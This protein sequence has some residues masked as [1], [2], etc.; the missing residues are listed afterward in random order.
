MRHGERAQ[1]KRGRADNNRFPC[2][3]PDPIAAPA[4]L[5]A[6][7]IASARALAARDGQPVLG[8][9]ERETGLT[10]DDLVQALGRTLAMGTVGSDELRPEDA[11]FDALPFAEAAER[12][13]VPIR[14]GGALSVVYADPFRSEV[15][16]WAQSR[17][18]EP[19]AWRLA[20]PDTIERFFRLLEES[21]RELDEVVRQAKDGTADRGPAACLVSLQPAD[22]R[23]GERAAMRLLASTLD[24]ALASG[25]SD[26][27]LETDPAGLVVKHRVDGVLATVARPRDAQLAGQV[28]AQLKANAGLDVA[29]RG[30][31]QAGR[32]RIQASRGVDLRLSILPGLHG[33]DAVLRILDKQSAA[34]E[35]RAPRLDRLGLQPH[36][37]AALHSLVAAPHGLVLL[38]GPA[39]C[40][41][42]TTAY[43]AIAQIR[44]GEHRIATLEDP[45]EQA[46]PGILQVAVDEAR[47]ITS[48]QGLRAILGHDPD[49]I[50]VGELRD[51]ETARIAVQAALGGRLVVATLQANGVLD[52]ASRVIDLGVDARA[53][54]AATRGI[55]AQRLV[56]LVCEQCAQPQ[57]PG[58]ALLAASGLERAQIAGWKI[59]GVNGCGQCRGSGYRGRRAIAEVLRVDDELRELIAKQDSVRA[60]RAAA[61]LKGTRTLRDAA[62]DLVKEGLTTLQEINRVI[63]VA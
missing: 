40:G 51:G 13:C 32:L 42:T 46:L 61:L 1:E 20:H 37:V 10:G 24:D 34:T 35:G 41:K 56:R 33:E 55:V 3:S 21:A 9:L 38:T 30:A 43:A 39:G 49:R 31:P 18:S 23:E 2:M 53:F 25:A 62:L 8:V 7:T 11:A 28:M 4:A 63:A 19:F 5:T 15:R 17:I 29:E 48:A 12:G 52:A 27:H 50:L 36:V 16:A 44:A 57:E 58:D 6:A 22:A 45:V 59:R 47:G 60:L 26:I 14:R 54:A